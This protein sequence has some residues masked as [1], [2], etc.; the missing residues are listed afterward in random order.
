MIIQSAFEAPGRWYRGNVHTHSVISDGKRTPAEIVAYYRQNGYDFVAFTDHLVWGDHRELSG[1]DFLVIPGIEIH[2]D[3]PESGT[4][5]LVGLGGNW[6]TG[7]QVEGLNSLQADIARLAA[8]QSLVY[9]AHPYWSGQLSHHFLTVD[10][11]IGLEVYNGT[12]DVG[13]GKGYSNQTWDDLLTAGRRLW[14]LAVDDTHWLPWRPDAGQGWIMVKATELTMEAIL[15]A[16]RHGRFYATQ[17]PAIHQVRVEENE[18]IISCSP[19]VLIHGLGQ[20]WLCNTARSTGG[21]G[22]TEAR[23]KLWPGQAYVRAEVVDRAGKRAWSNPIF[24]D[25]LISE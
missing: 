20:R 13:Y 12:C 19:A 23:F 21:L 2:G 8:R 4:Y 25:P 17:G 7:E 5:H 24:L 9:L 15:D 10:G 16:L 22:L 11:V 14:G 1:P 3:D 6:E 18:V